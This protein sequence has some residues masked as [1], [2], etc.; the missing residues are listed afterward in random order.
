M[1]ALVG[2]FRVLGLLLVLAEGSS[3]FYLSQRVIIF[4]Q[5]VTLKW[6]V[7]GTPLVYEPTNLYMY[8]LR[9]FTGSSQASD[10]VYTSNMS[11]RHA[12]SASKERTG[13][14][15]LCLICNVKITQKTPS[16]SCEICGICYRLKCTKVPKT[17]YD[18]L[19]GAS[20]KCGCPCVFLCPCCKPSLLSN[21]NQT[22]NAIKTSTSERFDTVMILSF[23][24]PKTF[25][26][27]TLKF[28][29]CGFTID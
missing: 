14:K 12:A 23:R 28:E 2:L 16:L 21:I 22:V 26:V 3:Y 5:N 7:A 13:P 29:L 1:K 27:I 6:K 17:V 8:S 24:T 25:V 4:S 15:D 10:F 11:S 19:V 18:A 20:N 9:E